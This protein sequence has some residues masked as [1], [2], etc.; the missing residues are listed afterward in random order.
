MRL[1]R[2]NDIRAESV[3]TKVYPLFPTIM[4]IVR[5][6]MKAL[7]AGFYRWLLVLWERDLTST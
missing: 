2:I 3:I 7:V 6:D 5:Y 1:I 4:W